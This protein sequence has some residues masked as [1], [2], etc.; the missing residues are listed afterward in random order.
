MSRDRFFKND[1]EEK[2]DDGLTR[3]FSFGSAKDSQFS[4]LGEMPSEVDF[5]KGKTPVDYTNYSGY[6]RAGGATSLPEEYNMSPSLQAMPSR[7]AILTQEDLNNSVNVSTAALE[8]AAGNSLSKGLNNFISGLKI[9]T[10]N[11]RNFKRT[12]SGFKPVTNEGL[13]AKN[14]AIEIVQEMKNLPTPGIMTQEEK[15]QS[16]IDNK[17][18]IAKQ[19]QK[20][21]VANQG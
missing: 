12:S 21:G 6:E 9:P 13:A 1:K 5:Y 10:N 2:V 20:E 11:T 19:M 3:D 17:N 8:G 18:A 4:G 7:Q 15:K 14:K 16:M